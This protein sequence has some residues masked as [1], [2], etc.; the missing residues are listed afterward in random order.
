ME[1]QFDSS[2]STTFVTF[3]AVRVPV[4]NLIGEENAGFMVIMLN[5]NHERF[6][7]AIGTCR[8]ARICFAEAFRYALERET[9]GRKLVGHQIIRFK[10]AEMARQVRRQQQPQQQ[11]NQQQQQQQ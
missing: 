9:F 4:S 11:R 8:V 5:F 6:G 2:H 1:T 10:L 3:D 7:M